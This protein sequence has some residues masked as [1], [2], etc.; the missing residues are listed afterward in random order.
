MYSLRSKFG[1]NSGP[2]LV[3]A[4]SKSSTSSGTGVAEGGATSA[5]P[6]VAA[7]AQHRGRSPLATYFPLLTSFAK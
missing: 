5:A 7:G 3:P 2:N 4:K 1:T 6:A